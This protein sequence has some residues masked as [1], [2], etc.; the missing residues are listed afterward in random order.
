MASLIIEESSSSAFD[1]HKKMKVRKNLKDFSYVFPSSSSCGTN[2]HSLT[3]GTE[4]Y[5]L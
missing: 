4:M 5:Y 3:N 1:K 2:K